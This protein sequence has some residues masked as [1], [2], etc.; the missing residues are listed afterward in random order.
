MLSMF[1]NHFFRWTEQLKDAGHEIYWLDVFDSNT[2]VKK[3]DFANQITGWRQKIKYPGRYTIKNKLPKFYDFINTINQRELATVF[4]E[5][6]NEIQPHVVH[7]FVMQ[8]ACFPII[9]LMKK[10]VEIPWIYSAWGNDLYFHQK[11]PAEISNREICFER[12]NY[13]FADCS[14]DGKIAQKMGFKGKYLGTFPTGG[15]Y[16]FKYHQKY[17]LPHKDRNIIL[18]KGYQ[19]TFGRCINILIAILLLKNK[20]LDY[21]IMVFGAHPEVFDFLENNPT[22]KKAANFTVYGSLPHD[23]IFQL[24]GKSLICIG[25]SIS[26]GMPNT[27]LEAI[28]MG[29]FPIQSNPGGATAEIIKNGKNGFLIE[30]A[31]DSDEIAAL[32]TKALEN[33]ELLQSGVDFNNKNIKPRLEREYIKKQVLE[34]YRFIE[35]N[36]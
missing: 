10:N 21:E 36:L 2:H 33:P 13:L 6:L 25:N 26:D 12:I 4:E 35:E 29:A 34:K 7:S 18:I 14:R 3:I 30:N 28:I 9:D 27:L 17:I 11:N 32:I 19:H 24:M 8:S 16:D 22:L 15:G 1:S 23:Q 5:K 20:L 31:E